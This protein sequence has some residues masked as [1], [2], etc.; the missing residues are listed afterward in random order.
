MCIDPASLALISTAASAG[1]ALLGVA[2]S[3][4]NAKA[5]SASANEQAKA[6][7]RKGIVEQEE[8]TRQERERQGQEVQN[9][10]ASGTSGA[11]GSPF[12]LALQNSENAAI[13]IRNVG[14]GYGQ[15]AA[16]VRTQGAAQAAGYRGQAL[17]GLVNA[18]STGVNGYQAYNRAQQN[19]IYL[20]GH[21]LPGV[22]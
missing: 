6:T 8:L 1:G 9:I 7:V 11:Y 2:Q 17:G 3:N 4:A 5:A 12:L 14:Q 18:V 15:A 22:V 20:S 13:N 21:S 16:D 10:A 19:R